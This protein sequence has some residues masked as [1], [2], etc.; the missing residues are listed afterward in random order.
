MSDRRGDALRLSDMLRS[1]EHL[2]EVLEEGYE[3][4]AKSWMRQSA[5]IRE[6]EIIGEAAG[7]LSPEIRKHNPDVGWE[8][9]RGF[10]SFAK[11]EYWRV[12][13]ELVW[14]A[15]KEMPALRELLRTLTTT[16]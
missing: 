16:S 9:M 13:P 1:V 5:V 14:Q 4:F 11:H 15:V 3:P 2:N 8:R 6:L 7:A 12:R 10:S